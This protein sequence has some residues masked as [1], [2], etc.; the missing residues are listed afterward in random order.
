MWT[1]LASSEHTMLWS[2]ISACIMT[3]SWQS[4]NIGLIHQRSCQIMP[5]KFLRSF[6]RSSISARRTMTRW[7]AFEGIAFT[8]A[9]RSYTQQIS[10][11]KGEIITVSQSNGDDGWWE[12]TIGDQTG[13]FPVA[14]A[15]PVEQESNG[16]G[17]CEKND[18]AFSRSH[19]GTVLR[20]CRSG[21]SIWIKRRESE[22]NAKAVQKASKWAL[23]CY[24]FFLANCTFV[25]HMHRFSRE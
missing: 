13:W 5:A 15:E 4:P 11:R 23:N 12:G 18:F 17:K 7:D 14:F 21:G 25:E 19:N 3:A 2:L 10:F 16:Q 1:Q 8:N 22:S 20:S 9:L 24:R 6:A